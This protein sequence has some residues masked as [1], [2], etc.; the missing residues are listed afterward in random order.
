[1]WES[2]I[3]NRRKN[4]EV[5]PEWLSIN[6]IRDSYGN[7]I[8]YVALFH[9]ITDIKQSEEKFQYQANYDAL[10][11]L[12]NRQLF[13]D[14]L[15][16]AMSRAR[17]NNSYVGVFFLDIDNF[18]NVN[19]SLGHY[20]GDQLL[21]QVAN[22]LSGCC[23]EEDTVARLGGDE[24][25]LISN[26]DTEGL[27]SAARLARRVIDIF[28][29]P[30]LIEKNE[31]YVS[32][33]V[34][35]S[36]YPDDGDEIEVLVKNADVAMYRAKEKGKNQFKL[37]TER[38]NQK[39]LRKIELS[40]ALRGALERGEFAVFY[41]PKVDVRKG[42]IAGLEALVRWNCNSKEM[43]SPYEFIPLAE[44]AGVISSIGEWV[45]ATACRDTLEF[46]SVCDHDLM[47]SVNLSVRQFRE[48]GLKD[49][50]KRILDETGFPP[51][52][53]TLEITESIV[54]DNIKKTIKVLNDINK[55]GVKVSI[56]DFGTGYSSLSYLKRMPLDELKIDKSFID[57]VPDD[58]DSSAIVTTII[59]LAK[60]LK[61]KTVAEGVETVE[62][63]TFLCGEECNEVQGYLF[64]KPLP[65][66]ALTKLLEE[67]TIM[68][69]ACSTIR[70]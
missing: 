62:Q 68:D 24:F 32:T 57:D 16:M 56:D 59:S 61:L 40:N 29:K 63:L 55:L 21:Q 53:L 50:I 25:L 23:R 4:G 54:I 37:Y 51:H 11:D 18:K 3:W 41:Q 67:T 9:D 66:Q 34:G 47:L 22:R 2:E 46:C 70:E 28:N 64:S 12:P 58:S 69:P 60:N 43:I 17:R 31:I 30:F 27:K 15:K 49:S 19:D 6:T 13:N 26:Y 7:I 42:K 5:Y 52:H 65:V 45:L 39:V 14:R 8:D 20:Y 36:I 48:E 35:I 10:T 38:M 44:D 33:S 1:V